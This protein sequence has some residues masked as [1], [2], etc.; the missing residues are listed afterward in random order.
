VRTAHLAMISIPAHGHVNPSLDVIRTLVER[1]HRVTYANA[2]SFG[3][4]VRGVGAE[5][6]PYR[7]TLP[8]PGESWTADQIDAL[9]LFLDDAIAM[10][11]QLE[12]AYAGD[13]PDLFL[14][15]IA[16]AP[17]RLL[18][19]RWGVPAVQLSPTFVGWDGYEQEMAPAIEAMRSD[20]RG[21]DYYRRYTEWL[22]A[23]GSTVT[24]SIAFQGRPERCLAL[25]PRAMQPHADRT[26]P[27]VVSFV[28]PVLGDRSD[29]G[30]WTRPE[31]A[32]KVLLVSLGS[33]FTDH[34]DFYR[35]CAAAFGELPGWHTV[36]QVG[37]H[38]DP[39][40]LGELP[41]TVEVHSWVPQLAVLEQADAFLTHA[42]MGGS[43]EGLYCGTPMIAAPQAADQFDNA[44]RLVTLGVARR[45]DSD[46]VTVAELRAALV[47][48]VGDPDVRRRTAELRRELR[49]QAGADRAADLIEAE[50][51]RSPAQA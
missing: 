47:D 12:T 8:G 37:R 6:K 41:A 28:G 33:E 22:T 35:R 43:S 45:I 23:Q 4:V 10:L 30:T 29:Q 48:L 31:Q 7:S 2:P 36:L 27:D 38:V 11:P 20:P 51:I 32:E 26:D 34:P 16:G 39:G 17:A 5:F 9:T 42:G 18:A 24:D 1:G 40:A 13:R 15:D 14:Y 44:D 50:L 25:I 19:Q 21:A 46:T 49:E 3:D